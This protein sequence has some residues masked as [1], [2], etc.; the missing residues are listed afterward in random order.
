MVTDRWTTYATVLAPPHEPA[1][2]SWLC[3]GD[4]TAWPCDV[5]R[6]QLAARH[7][8]ALATV[9]GAQ[10]VLAA[11][12]TPTAHPAELHERFVAWT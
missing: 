12:D 6:A 4:G 7:R 1:R 10:L 8:G 2:P 9:L 11:R 5:A 3:L